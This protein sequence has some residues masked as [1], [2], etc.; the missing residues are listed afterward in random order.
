MQMENYSPD[1]YAMSDLAIL[2]NIGRFTKHTR[3]RKN[4]TQNDLAE[5]AGI[6]RIT[7]SNL[8]QGKRNISLL[9]FIELLRALDALETIDNF[10]IRNTI[11]PILL[12]KLEAKKRKRASHL[13]KD[14]KDPI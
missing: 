5:R 12:A 10:K 13:R 7:I 6:H 9:T 8:E 4:Y 11:S 3:L 1:W 2:R 14:R